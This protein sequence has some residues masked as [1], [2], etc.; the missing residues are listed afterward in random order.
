MAGIS[1][2]ATRQIRDACPWV[3][4][5]VGSE[6]VHPRVRRREGCQL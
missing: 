3:H 6:G 2:A 5:Y 1:K 4:S